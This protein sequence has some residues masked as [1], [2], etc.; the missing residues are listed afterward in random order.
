MSSCQWTAQKNY[1]NESKSKEYIV[2]LQ[3][4]AS[5]CSTS[6]LSL[7][8]LNYLGECLMCWLLL[9][10]IWLMPIPM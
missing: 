7:G 8:L 2:G 10:T 9:F 6:S 4:H 5:Y 3:C 1:P